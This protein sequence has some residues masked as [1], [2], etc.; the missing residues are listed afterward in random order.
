MVVPNGK[1]G[2]TFI[3]NITKPLLA[4]SLVALSGRNIGLKTHFNT[5]APDTLNSL[6][7]ALAARFTTV[8]GSSADGNVS[9]T[10]TKCV[11]SLPVFWK[12]ILYVKTESAVEIFPAGETVFRW[13]QSYRLQCLMYAGGYCWYRNRLLQD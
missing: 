9:V 4:G 10:I 12:W 2:F 7:G 5:P 6:N 11:V 3:L 8:V 13:G 1:L